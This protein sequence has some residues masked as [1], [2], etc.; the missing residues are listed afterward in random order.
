MP[1]ARKYFYFPT[2]LER[3]REEQERYGRML[4]PAFSEAI[5][6]L[7]GL[8]A[9]T[10]SALFEQMVAPSRLAFERERRRGASRLAARGIGNIRAAQEFGADIAERQAAQESALMAEARQRAIAEMLSGITGL[11]GLMEAI[12]GRGLGFGGQLRMMYPF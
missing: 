10:P 11:T 7:R 1:Y 12:K 4:E 3:E 2:Y 9:T 6:R 8:G 5:E